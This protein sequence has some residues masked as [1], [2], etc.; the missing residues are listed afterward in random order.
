[1][2]NISVAQA[3][4]PF[5]PVTVTIHSKVDLANVLGALMAYGTGKLY[6][7][8]GLK[9]VGLGDFYSGNVRKAAREM[10]LAIATATN[11]V[12][13]PEFTAYLAS[14]TFRR[15]HPSKAG[16]AVIGTEDDLAQGRSATSFESPVTPQ[17]FV[18]D[19]DEDDVAF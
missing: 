19:E 12:P 8:A 17:P 7:E 14:P 10:A 2:P 18:A 6:A 5:T 16:A 9:A 15:S 1:M 4:A 11:V 3:P 13:L